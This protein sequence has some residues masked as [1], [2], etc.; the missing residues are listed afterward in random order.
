MKGNQI[1]ITVILVVLVGAAGFFG[2][3]QYQRVQR[4]AGA[5]GFARRFGGVGQ[6]G[7]APVR[8][9]ILSSD[10][11]SITVK[12]ADGSGKIVL[13]NSGTMITQLATASASDLKEG[14]QVL[15]LGTINPD[16]SVTATNV[17]LNPKVMG[18]LRNGAGST[19][20]SASSP[21][22]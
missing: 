12:L 6:N 20:I 22:Y 4:G 17:S 8:G 2:G 9:Q 15:V 21:S 16:G 5:G 10:A 7:A 18:F 3:M 19:G 14:K 1:I 11:N 13:I